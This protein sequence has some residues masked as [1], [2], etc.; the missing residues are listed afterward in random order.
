MEIFFEG[1]IFPKVGNDQAGNLE[2]PW[3]ISEITK[4][5]KAM[6]SGKTPGPDGFPIEFF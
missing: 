2:Q 1:I 3:N 4:S 5:I 6:Q